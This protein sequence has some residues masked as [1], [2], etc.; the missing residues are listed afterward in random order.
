MFGVPVG[1]K[2]GYMVGHMMKSVMCEGIGASVVDEEGEKAYYVEGIFMQGDVLNNNKR[3]YPTKILGDAVKEYIDTKIKGK[4]AWGE[5]GHPDSPK[6]NLDKVAILVTDLS[7][8]NDDFMGRARVCHEDCPMGKILRGLIKTGGKVGVSSRGLGS[9]NPHKHDGEDCNL[10]DAF[11]L[12]AIDVV[13][14]PSA[15]D[16]MVEAVY[17]EKQYILD[18]S[19]DMV[20]ELNEETYKMFEDKMKVLP[21]KEEPKQE[22]IFEAVKLF[23]NGLRSNTK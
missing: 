3:V 4:S 19:S 10:V 18:G 22:Q 7:Q 11:N 14:D 23:L 9:A 2:D 13:A 15:P 12:R 17:E 21:V 5:L 8:Q 16:A 1:K 6:I 20:L